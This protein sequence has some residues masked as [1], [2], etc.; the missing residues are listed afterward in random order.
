MPVAAALP[1]SNSSRYSSF[2]LYMDRIVRLTL[3]EWRVQF[4]DSWAVGGT[5]VMDGF[6]CYSFLLFVRTMLILLKRMMMEAS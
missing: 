3:C 5:F 6:R 4:L 2:L 1:L